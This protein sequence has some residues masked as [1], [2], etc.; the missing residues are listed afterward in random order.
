M[1]DQNPVINANCVGLDMGEYTIEITPR[2]TLAYAAAIDALEEIYFDDAGPRG[3]VAPPPFTV[4]LEWPIMITPKYIAGL[5]LNRDNIFN[6]LVHAF[7]DTFFHRAIRPGDRLRVKGRIAQVRR[8][9]A[10]T[11][12]VCRITTGNTRSRE[13][14][15]EGWFGS[16][17]RGVPIAG[18]E[19]TAVEPP[20]LRNEPGLEGF[21]IGSTRIE[22][23]RG[24]PHIYSECAHIWNPIHTERSFALRK[25]LPDIILQGTCTWAKACMAVIRAHAGGNPLRLKRFGGRFSRMV[26]PGSHIVVEHRADPAARGHV[27]FAVRNAAGEYAITHGVAVI[28]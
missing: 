16:L 23:P 7:Q 15:S 6:D 5:G 18:E 19:G 3:I 25:R 9:S 11:V 26:I 27:H 12:V 28:A 24:L 8:T 22:I 1:T 2:R 13:L 10:G 20:S 21:G 17:F 4:S 14:V